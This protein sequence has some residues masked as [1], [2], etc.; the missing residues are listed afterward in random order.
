MNV[1]NHLRIV[2]KGLSD[3]LDCHRNGQQ[4]EEKGQNYRLKIKISVSARSISRRAVEN[5]SSCQLF[6]KLVYGFKS[7]RF[8]V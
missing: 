3:F 2:K 1:H 7:Q 6:A 4:P 5:T 8:P